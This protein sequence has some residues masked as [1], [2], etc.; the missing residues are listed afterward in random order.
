[1]FNLDG[2]VASESS[3]TQ[4]DLDAWLVA[5]AANQEQANT[6]ERQIRSALEQDLADLQTLIDTPN[7]TINAG[8]A[9]YIK[10][11]ARVV[12]HLVRMAIRRFD[13]VA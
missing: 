8:P 7:Q 12:R 4:A 2:S 5:R 11:L 6:V 1:V 10:A 3:F 9:P 13:A